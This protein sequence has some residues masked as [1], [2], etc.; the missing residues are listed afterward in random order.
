VKKGG[1][2]RDRIAKTEGEKGR[3]ARG[4]Y[5]MEWKGGK[6]KINKRGHHLMLTETDAEACDEM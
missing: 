5:S 6:E 4:N 2:R 3:F 1:I